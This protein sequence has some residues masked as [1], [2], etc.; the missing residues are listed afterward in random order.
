MMATKKN[1]EAVSPVIGTILMV[2]V[3]V[4]LAAV[5]ASYVFG[6]AGNVQKT[7]VVAAT[8][9]MTT[10][11]D[12]YITY[13]GGQNDDA[14]T[15]LTIAAPNGTTTFY[16]SSSGGTLT[17][18]PAAGCETAIDKAKPNVGTSMKLNPG[19]DWPPSQK[20]IVVTGTFNDGGSQIILDTFV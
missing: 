6:T 11:G 9:Q 19:S 13:Q 14:L 18:C 15:Y 5:I 16:T 1:E 17:V 20:H 7:K 8:A 12:I 4:I 10:T 3:T 2:A